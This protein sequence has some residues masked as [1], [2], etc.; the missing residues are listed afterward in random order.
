MF[1][2]PALIIYITLQ[3]I[4]GTIPE[5]LVNPA[6]IPMGTHQHPF[7]ETLKAI[8]AAIPTELAHPKIGIVCGSGL[9]TLASHFKDKIE[10]PY[11]GLPGFVKVRVIA[12]SMEACYTNFC[13]VYL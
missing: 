11:D 2:Y 7:E 1:V 12:Q 9:S 3:Y 4:S 6:C 10:V 8:R 5:P 13:R